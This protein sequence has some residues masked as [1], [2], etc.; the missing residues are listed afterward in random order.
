MEIQQ[1]QFS[2][3]EIAQY[4]DLS[5]VHYRLFWN[6]GKSKS[7]H[8]GYWDASTKNLHEALLNTNKVLSETAHISGEDVVLDAGC[9]VGGSSVWLAK[10]IGCK[11][12]GITLSEKQAMQAAQYAT[13]QGVADLA[14]FAVNDYT[15]TGYP[16]K[17]FSV[18]WA[19]ETVCHA[20]DKS[21]FLREAA[22]V[23]KPGGRLIMADFFK[24]EGLAGKDAQMIK[25]WANGWA[26]DDYATREEFER[27]L[28]SEGFTNVRIIDASEAVMPSIKKL[29]RAYLLGIVPSRIYNLFHPNATEFGKRNVD[30]ARLQY[31]TMKKKLWNY[32]IVYAEKAAGS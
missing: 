24:K 25:D 7:L 29:Y 31:V 2:K 3:K 26:V 14:S 15:N 20:R 4:Y 9:G 11:A 12:T 1:K 8:Y 6:L 22:R 5:E 30:T 28:Q 10:N 32:L 18:V 23:L 27:L 19:V 21:D 13:A 16:E 17:S